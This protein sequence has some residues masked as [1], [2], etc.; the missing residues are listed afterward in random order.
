[1]EDVDIYDFDKT[2]VPFESGTKFI[3]YCVLHYPWIIIYTPILFVSS[4]LALLHIMS[5]DF[6][7]KLCFMFVP[8]I[9]L[10]RAVEGFW[11]KHE[12]DFSD[13]FIN[14]NKERKTIVVSASPDFLIGG[15]KD[16]LDIDTLICTKHSSKN[17]AIMGE[18]CR[19]EEKV[20]RLY[21]ELG[22][23]NINVIDV[24]SDSIKKDKPIFSLATGQCYQI[25]NKK[26]IPFNFN[27]IYKD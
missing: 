14:R 20:R 4:F 6:Y 13:W 22:K 2:I 7:K 3:C 8:M 16:R 5:I 21:E 24:Y 18:N 11:K 12:K 25:V 9:P 19:S 10:E 27:E 15:L 17:G 26:I 23:E 1:M